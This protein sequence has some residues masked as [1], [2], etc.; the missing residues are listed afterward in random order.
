MSR[1]DFDKIMTDFAS[2]FVVT[3]IGGLATL[4][5]GL[6][7]KVNTNSAQLKQDRISHLAQIELIMAELRTKEK[8]RDEDRERMDRVEDDIR[9]SRRDI[10]EIKNA[11]IGKGS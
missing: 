5:I 8:R 1:L 2:W 6:W 9:E 3:I 10:Q 4:A 11:L 7:R